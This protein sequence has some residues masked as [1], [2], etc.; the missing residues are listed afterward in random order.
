MI[1]NLR[2]WSLTTVILAGTASADTTLRY[3]AQGDCP[4][5]ADSVEISGALMR[6]DVHEQGQ[7]YYSVFDGDEGQ[8]TTMMP[9]QH[10][11]HQ[12]EVDEALD[13][14]GGVADN[15]DTYIDSQM[16]KMQAKVQQQCADLQRNSGTCAPMP[17]M[18]STIQA[19]AASQ[20][21]TEVR[22]SGQRKTVAGVACSVFEMLEN[23]VKKQEVCYAQPEDL[24][25]PDP[26]RKGLAL[27][28][29]VMNRYGR[30]FTGTAV[31][32]A[33]APVQAQT[34]QGLPVAQSCFD[35]AGK[36]SGQNS[37]SIAQDK[38]APERFDIPSDYS[39]LSPQD[40]PAKP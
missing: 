15:A 23:G 16:Q 13:T 9:A 31:H 37:V 12:V 36:A 11:Y 22:D 14:A 34:P 33:A 35:A 32:L 29:K 21:R 4:A 8:Y 28:L 3:T 7:E 30:A 19:V 20:P 25:I 5:I 39:K 27:G 1:D 6:F 10:K 17:D 38:I 40:S 2:L 24:P 26:D 18:S